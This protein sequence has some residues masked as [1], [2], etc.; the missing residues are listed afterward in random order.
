ME[1]L[2]P[3]NEVAIF[4]QLEIF[5]DKK[6]FNFHSFN[7]INDFVTIQM[8]RIDKID[9]IEWIKWIEYCS[10]ILQYSIHFI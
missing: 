7:K 10:S 4:F 1:T 6:T 9:K 3:K 5:G 8:N 2:S